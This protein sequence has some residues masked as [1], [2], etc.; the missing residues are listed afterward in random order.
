MRALPLHVIAAGTGDQGANNFLT[1]SDFGKALAMLCGA[2]GVLVVVACIFRMVK[3][4]TSGKPGEGFKVLVFGLVIGAL[5]FDLN[6]TIK[7]VDQA[8]TLVGKAFNSISQVTG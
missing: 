1:N 7:G 4:I 2:F 5:L 3:H 6:L 8:G